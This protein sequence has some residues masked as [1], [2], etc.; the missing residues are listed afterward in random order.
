M[1]RTKTLGRRPTLGTPE[2]RQTS[3]AKQLEQR[4][5]ESSILVLTVANALRGV[6]TPGVPPEWNGTE[7][8]RY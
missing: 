5:I 6:P 3:T 8:V 7:S 4:M 1:N 2:T